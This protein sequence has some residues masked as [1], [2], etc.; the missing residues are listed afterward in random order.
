M[1]GRNSQL[2]SQRFNVKANKIINAFRYKIGKSESHDSNDNESLYTVADPLLNFLSGFELRVK[3]LWLGHHEMKIRTEREGLLS[4][5]VSQFGVY[6]Y[7]H[8]L[9]EGVIY[10]RKNKCHDKLSWPTYNPFTLREWGGHG[11]RSAPL[12]TVLTFIKHR[13]VRPPL[14]L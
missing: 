7:H 9:L 10:S 6:G 13:T 4:F 12:G 3:E 1:V 8:V 14:T 11:K 5:K 2:H